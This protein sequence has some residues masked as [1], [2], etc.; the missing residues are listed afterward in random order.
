MVQAL[1]KVLQYFHLESR[2]K[3]REVKPVKLSLNSS[4][5][6]RMEGG[7]SEAGGAIAYVSLY[8]LRKEGKTQAEGVATHRVVKP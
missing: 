7:A 1:L 4:K 3:Y 8:P 6:M 2:R 5:K